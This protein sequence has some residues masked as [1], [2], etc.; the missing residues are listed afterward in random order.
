MRTSPRKLL[1]SIMTFASATLVAGTM[2]ACSA[3][4]APE[5]EA[6][7]DYVFDQPAGDKVS[8]TTVDASGT[9]AH[10]EED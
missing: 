4:I 9:A 10:G 3:M 7:T 2:A 8:S 6:S 5:E 1:K